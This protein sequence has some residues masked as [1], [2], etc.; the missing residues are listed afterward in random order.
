[1]NRD[2]GSV[3]ECAVEEGES[4]KVVKCVSFA[5]GKACRNFTFLV[6]ARKRK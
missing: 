4:L 5:K 2:V 3:G 1:M 6:N